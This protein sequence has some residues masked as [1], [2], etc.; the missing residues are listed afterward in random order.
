MSEINISYLGTAGSILPVVFP[1]VH[2]PIKGR[3]GESTPC[4]QPVT[5][6]KTHIVCTEK[7]HRDVVQ[8]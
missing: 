3:A 6:E 1:S 7:K 5:K 4:Y 2:S 8:V